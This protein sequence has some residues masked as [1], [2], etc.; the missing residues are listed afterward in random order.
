[1]LNSTAS[2]ANAHND[3]HHAGS[4]KTSEYLAF[5][6]GKEEYGIDIQLVQEIRGYESVTRIANAPDF[7]K[8]V[9]NLRGVIVPIID[10]RIKFELG[11]PTY[12]SFTVVI[13]L[14]IEN[15]IVG[16]VVDSVS[17]VINLSDQQ[18]K[19]A[20]ELGS[21]IDSSFLRGLAPLDQRMV[22]LID[23]AL[24]MKTPDM[25]LQFGQK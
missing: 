10:L 18:V 25:G 1:M 3:D 17:D 5:R 19:P 15:T 14:H 24:L 6:L 13:I 8:G 11:E 2:T 4:S 21:T 16:I 7:M 23:I 20:P 12:D 9:M 22:I